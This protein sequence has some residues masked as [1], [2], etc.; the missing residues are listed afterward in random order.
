MIIK[1]LPRQTFSETE[2]IFNESTASL[3]PCLELLQRVGL[4]DPLATKR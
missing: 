1:R 2:L 4:P 3:P